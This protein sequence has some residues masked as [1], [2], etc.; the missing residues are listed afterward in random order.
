MLITHCGSCPLLPS[1]HQGS[2]PSGLVLTHI[3]MIELLSI[4]PL[5]ETRG[6]P[7]SSAYPEVQFL[8]PICCMP[9]LLSPFLYYRVCVYVR[10]RVCVRAWDQGAAFDPVWCFCFFLLADISVSVTVQKE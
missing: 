9:K 6:K 5:T 7:L 2:L 3:G 4:R 10:G 1:P 8:T